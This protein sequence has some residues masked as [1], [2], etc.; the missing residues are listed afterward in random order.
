MHMN[1]V[2]Q[3]HRFAPLAI[4]GVLA[5]CFL[6]ATRTSD[7]AED[8]SAAVRNLALAYWDAFLSGDKA[9]YSAAMT[10]Q[11]PLA[12]VHAVA[13]FNYASAGRRLHEALQSFGAEGEK[14]STELGLS[15]PDMTR[16]RVL[17]GQITINGDLAKLDEE[18]SRGRLHWRFR[19]VDGKWKVDVTPEA[20]DPLA[21]N[22]ESTDRVARARAAVADEIVAGKITSASDA[23]ASLQKRMMPPA[24]TR[25]T[26]RPKSPTTRGA[27]RQ[28]TTAKTSQ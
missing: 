16:D 11:E 28:P 1:I 19:N 6:C 2:F 8:E 5:L 27:T 20:P 25:P 3:R 12:L 14:L 10:S 22:I 4:G 15:S 24:A 23:R 13:V 26:T 17:N 9:A 21:K 7:A 18:D